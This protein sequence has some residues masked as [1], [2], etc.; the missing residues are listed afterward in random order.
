MSLGG[1]SIS[2]LIDQRL[3][4]E[5]WDSTLLS[6]P[7]LLTLG[8]GICHSTRNH[9]SSSTFLRNVTSLPTMTRAV[10]IIMNLVAGK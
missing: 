6:K 2:I 9:H 4:Q 3:S 8:Q 10:L 7:T 5:L 1:F